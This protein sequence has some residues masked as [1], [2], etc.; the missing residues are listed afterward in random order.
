MFRLPNL[1]GRVYLSYPPLLATIFV[2]GKAE[3]TQ[4]GLPT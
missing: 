2:S 1:L 3:S 4:C